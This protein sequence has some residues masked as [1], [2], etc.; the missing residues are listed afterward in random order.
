MPEIYRGPKECKTHA[1]RFS[2]DGEKWA[3]VTV[4]L[5]EDGP[6]F[7][8]DGDGEENTEVYIEAALAYERRLSP[9]EIEQVA[10]A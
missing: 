3:Q 1:F 9:A 2:L 10:N 5:D 8:L 7:Y 6:V 4:V